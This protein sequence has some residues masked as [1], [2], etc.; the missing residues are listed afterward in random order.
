[1]LLRDGGLPAERQRELA[2]RWCDVLRDVFAPF[3]SV[4]LHE[5][6]R[7]ANDRAARKLAAYVYAKAAFEQMPILADALEDAGPSDD[8]LLPHLRSPG[9][10][11]RGCWALDLILAR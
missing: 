7:E 9:P 5:G 1:A 10:H 4:I 8:P 11:V 3:Q 2:R 6:W